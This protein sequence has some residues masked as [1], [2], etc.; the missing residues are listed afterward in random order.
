MAL[1][2]SQS[3]I[4]A[5]SVFQ[6]DDE[7]TGTGGREGNANYVRD[8]FAQQ[9]QKSTRSI[10]A[11]PGPTWVPAFREASRVVNWSSAAPLNTGWKKNS[12]LSFALP[13]CRTPATLLSFALPKIELPE[14]QQD[15]ESTEYPGKDMATE[16]PQIWGDLDQMHSYHVAKRRVHA[17]EEQ[18]KSALKEVA[19]ARTETNSKRTEMEFV[20]AAKQK[21]LQDVLSEMDLVAEHREFLE[22]TLEDVNERKEMQDYLLELEMQKDD[23]DTT[24]GDVNVEI[25]EVEREMAALRAGLK[26]LE[27]EL[28]HWKMIVDEQ[29]KVTTNPLIQQ[30]SRLM[31]DPETQWHLGW[32]VLQPLLKEVCC[33]LSR[34]LGWGNSVYVMHLGSVQPFPDSSQQ[35]ADLREQFYPPQ[36]TSALVT[37]YMPV[38]PSPGH[39]RPGNALYASFALPRTPPPW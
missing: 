39:L 27:S 9:S 36:D 19:V 34:S 28:S 38:L 11:T 31:D 32:E 24:L 4:S 20:T 3:C 10:L 23:E 6:S 8:V 15:A 17:L 18:V 1:V 30:I 33:M 22:L 14:V 29:Q 12:V 16:N 37:P 25:D 21:E 26:D 35:L 5:Q 7:D 2:S 13:R